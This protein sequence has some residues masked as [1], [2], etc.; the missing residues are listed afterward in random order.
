MSS[1]KTLTRNENVVYFTVLCLKSHYVLCHT[2][3]L[4]TQLHHVGASIRSTKYEKM[5]F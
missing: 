5:Q 4:V 3:V 2:R 1:E